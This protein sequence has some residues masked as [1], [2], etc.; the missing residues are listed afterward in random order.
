[1]GVYYGFEG[2]K[3]SSKSPFQKKKKINNLVIYGIQF[4][5]PHFLIFMA[6]LESHW[7]WSI[8]L[9]AIPI[10]VLQLLI[11]SSY[12]QFLNSLLK[13][14]FR[15]VKRHTIKSIDKNSQLENYIINFL[16]IT[17]IKS[18][19]KEP[20]MS[21]KQQKHHQVWKTPNVAKTRKTKGIM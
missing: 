2:C 21:A 4:V 13:H 11:P 3:F 6:F 15:T 10:I 14:S 20:Y 7:P 18:N 5:M 1:M 19:K 12:T 9:K 17:D 16:T 8:A